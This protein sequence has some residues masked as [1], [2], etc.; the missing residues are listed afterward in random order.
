MT[1]FDFRA[2]MIPFGCFSLGQA[3]GVFPNMDYSNLTRWT[4]KGYLVHLRQN[5][6]AFHEMN[7]IPDFNRHIAE[8]IYRPSYLSLHWALAFYGIIPEAVTELTSVTTLKTSHFSN[9][10][11]E[12]DYQTIKPSLM[13][14]Y[15]QT[16]TTNGKVYLVAEPEKALVDL[17]YLNST[18]NTVDDMLNLRLDEDYMLNEFCWDT[19]DKYAIRT[20]SKILQKRTEALKQAYG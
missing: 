9:P 8:R 2:Q 1:Y 10:F 3:R 14:G 16:Q 4:G 20:G 7:D 15:R 5:W 18:Y 12:F 6:Y 19:L 17:L 11:G 13:W